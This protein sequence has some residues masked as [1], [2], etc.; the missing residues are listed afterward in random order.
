MRKKNISSGILPPDHG[1]SLLHKNNLDKGP[2]PFWLSTRKITCRKP[3]IADAQSDLYA[4]AFA[5]NKQA[6]QISCTWCLSQMHATG[7]DSRGLQRRTAIPTSGMPYGIMHR[8][9]YPCRA[10]QHSHQ[11]I[12]TQNG[13]AIQTCPLHICIEYPGGTIVPH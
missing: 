13:T 2:F 5:L 7:P 11:L 10:N 6:V 12:H 9:R 3:G 1:I 8:Q 4:L